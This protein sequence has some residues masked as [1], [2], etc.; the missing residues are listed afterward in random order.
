MSI[1]NC[2]IFLNFLR[3]FVSMHIGRYLLNM[4]GRYLPNLDGQIRS[5]ILIA[6]KYSE[7]T[8]HMLWGFRSYNLIL[9]LHEVFLSLPCSVLH[10]HSMRTYLPKLNLIS[11]FTI[12]SILDPK[13]RIFLDIWGPAN[14]MRGFK[15]NFLRTKTLYFLQWQ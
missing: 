11:D 1:L 14:N 5:K 6:I 3:M 7:A 15:S 8:T 2:L 13:W 12:S 4:M 10:Y 9:S